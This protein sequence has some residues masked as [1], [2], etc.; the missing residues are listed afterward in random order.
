[1]RK[2]RHS[3]RR[4]FILFFPKLINHTLSQP[5]LPDVLHN[6]NFEINPG[7]KVLVFILPLLTSFTIYFQ[8]GI[9]G[10]TGSGKSTLALSFFRFVEATEG[11]ILVDELDI[12]Q[13]GLTDLRTKLT[14]IPREY[15]RTESLSNIKYDP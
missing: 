4:E 10:R 1:M 3:I 7:E 6:L 5:D 9:L 8:V 13:M 14:I 15:S 2:S 12:A 11:R